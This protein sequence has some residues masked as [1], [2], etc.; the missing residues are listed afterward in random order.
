MASSAEIQIAVKDPEELES[1]INFRRPGDQELTA[2]M[3]TEQQHPAL[4]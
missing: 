3:F 2:D 4:L 1:P